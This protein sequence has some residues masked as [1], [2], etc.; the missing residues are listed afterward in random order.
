MPNTYLTPSASRHSTNTSLARRAAMLAYPSP[1]GV[2][3]RARRYQP[4]LVRP[5]R[6]RPH[7]S[8]RR[9]IPAFCVLAALS[10]VAEAGA[11]ASK[12][13]LII[14]GRGFGHGVGM[15]QWGAYGYA[16]H[17]WDHKAILAHYYTGTAIGD[18]SA[19]P[20]VR[21][22]LAAGR[23]RASFTQATS[24]GG[25]RLDPAK[26]YS[27][28]SNG[29][30]RHRAAQPVGPRARPRAGA[31]RITGAGAPVML[32]ALGRRGPQRR[33][34]AARW[35]SAPRPSAAWT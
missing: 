31:L 9:L 2:G 27:V 17:G 7:V 28:T 21:V 10:P 3:I 35:T 15:S 18:A 6:V 32:R 30:G 8:R 20:A 34:T 12:G 23:A 29:L 5:R 11:A 14:R 1:D 25:R 24:A 22:L 33:A 19:A 26:T 16:L 13:T 4:Q